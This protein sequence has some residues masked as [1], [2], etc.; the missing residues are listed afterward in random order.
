MCRHWANV[1][2]RIYRSLGT[3]PANGSNQPVPVITLGQ[4][5]SLVNGRYR[6]AKRDAKIDLEGQ[7][8]K[9]SVAAS[10]LEICGQRAPKQ[11]LEK[12]DRPVA[13]W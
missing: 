4:L 12:G 5:Q 2:F 1:G 9:D 6:E 3:L 11:S 7:R 10:V 13:V 8:P